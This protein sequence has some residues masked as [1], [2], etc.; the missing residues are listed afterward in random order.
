ML[1]FFF[2]LMLS[3]ALLLLLL[4]IESSFQ[5]A[6]SDFAP[7]VFKTGMLSWSAA[8]ENKKICGSA[9]DLASIFSEDARRNMIQFPDLRGLIDVFK[10]NLMKMLLFFFKNHECNHFKLTP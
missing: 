9:L 8:W 4:S 2:E 6:F 5:P 7:G 1:F 3:S 10:M